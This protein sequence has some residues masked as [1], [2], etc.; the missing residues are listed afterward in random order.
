VALHELGGD[1]GPDSPVN[2]NWAGGHL[3][4]DD[5]DDLDDL[6]LPADDADTREVSEISHPPPARYF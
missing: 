1:H 5:P 2:P 4:L 3:V 6:A